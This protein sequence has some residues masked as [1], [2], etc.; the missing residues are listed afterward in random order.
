M[1]RVHRL[2]LGAMQN[3][4]YIIAD[5]SGKAAVIDPAWDSAAIL[6][7]AAAHQLSIEK[8]LLTHS[9]F[10][11]VNAAQQLQNATGAPIYLSQAELNFWKKA[12]PDCRILND[13]DLIHIGS[14]Q[15]QAILTA[16]H[17]QGSLC[18]LI[19]DDC[20]TGDTLFIYGCGRCDF[21]ES[22]VFAMFA[23]LQK[24]K[25]TLSPQ[26]II[27]PGHDYGISATSTW[28]QQLAGNPFLL[29]EDPAAFA[30]FRLHDHSQLRSQPYDAVDQNWLAEYLARQN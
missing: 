8:I 11:H 2:S 24:L 10:D 12:P 9:H 14:S 17:T 7:T 15:I 26:T 1:H 5:A 29:L 3:F 30:Q 6:K 20:F 23:S 13:G 4:I 16:G 25:A 21:K 19:G 27:H 18:Y 22:D 28:Q